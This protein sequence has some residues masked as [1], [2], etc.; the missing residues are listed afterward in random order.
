[1]SRTTEEKP[2]TLKNVV[3]VGNSIIGTT[4]FLFIICV[5]FGSEYGA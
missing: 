3:E 2:V 4:V 5:L 1:M